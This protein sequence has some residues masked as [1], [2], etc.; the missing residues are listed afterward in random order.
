[1]PKNSLPLRYG[2]RRV[3]GT[4]SGMGEGPF[5]RQTR[6]A[7]LSQG[8]RVREATALEGD[9]T[10]AKLEIIPCE[11]ADANEFVHRT[12]RHHGKVAG[13]KF[14][15]AVVDES[16]QIRGVAIVGR[17]VARRLDDGWTLE[18]NR[19]ATDGCPNACSALY[20][21]ARRACFAL[22]Y[23]KL[24]TYTL[25]SEGG[26]SLRAAGWRLIG[27]AG[28]GSWNCK[29]RPRVD[30]APTQVKLRWEVP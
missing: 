9:V 11:L 5:L 20:G 16:G 29:T 7:D 21:A 24:I 22:G 25:P 23:K 26:G 17:P 4:G 27:E 3:P 15:V 12:H 30:K 13:H 6:P 28:G 18:V 1:M 2:A 10:Q 8:L 19:V 14:S